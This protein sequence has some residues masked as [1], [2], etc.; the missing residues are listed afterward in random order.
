MTSLQLLKEKKY[1]QIIGIDYKDNNDSVVYKPSSKK[2]EINYMS[3][4]RRNKVN[5]KKHDFVLH[6][7]NRYVNYKNV[8]YLYRIVVGYMARTKVPGRTDIRER[9]NTICYQRYISTSDVRL[10][11]IPMSLSASK[12]FLSLWTWGCENWEVNLTL[13]IDASVHRSA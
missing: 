10:Q 11:S 7:F 4:I 6:N 12:I 8:W 1:R 5:K 9:K 3:D 2:W 13:M